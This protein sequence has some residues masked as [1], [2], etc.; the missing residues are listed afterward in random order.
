MSQ[1]SRSDVV[2]RQIEIWRSR[3]ARRPAADH[4]SVCGYHDFTTTDDEHMPT[5]ANC[6]GLFLP[7][8]AARLSAPLPLGTAYGPPLL[9]ALVR[10]PETGV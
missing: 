4:G 6:G 7:L 9:A 8:V 2:D 3:A 10:R 1:H 5:K